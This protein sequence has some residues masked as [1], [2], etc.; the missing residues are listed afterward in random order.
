M[1]PRTVLKSPPIVNGPAHKNLL[2]RAFEKRPS[3][4]TGM[5][6]EGAH[7]EV[8]TSCRLVVCHCFG[9]WYGV[10]SLLHGSL[11]IGGKEHRS[12]ARM[13]V[14]PLPVNA[15]G[16]HHP[17]EILLA[18]SP[19]GAL[20]PAAVN[21]VPVGHVVTATHGLLRQRVQCIGPLDIGGTNLPGLC[22]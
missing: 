20:M 14:N 12:G 7:S 13:N 10:A 8:F 4:G 15:S 3:R 11:T 5:T 9:V 22:D 18:A 1:G 21:R 17:A 16:F 6:L 2:N 19:A